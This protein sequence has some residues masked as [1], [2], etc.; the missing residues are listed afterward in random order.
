MVA[1]QC[2]SILTIIL[3]RNHKKKHSVQAN[4]APSNSTNKD[5]I[6]ERIKKLAELKELGIVT[7]EEFENK[8]SELI[9]R[10]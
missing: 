5:D 8:K 9:A 2:V 7:A 10:L 3:K 4:S 1:D 6:I